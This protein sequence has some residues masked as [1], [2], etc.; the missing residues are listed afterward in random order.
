MAAAYFVAG[1]YYGLSY[2]QRKDYIVGC[3]KPSAALTTALY[4]AMESYMEGDDKA[5]EARGEADTQALYSIALE[6]CD[7]VTPYLDEYAA[8]FDALREREDWDAI[9]KQI[10]EDHQRASRSKHTIVDK[11]PNLEERTR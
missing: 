11:L 3:F 1:W 8:E 9:S 2:M 7:E 6:D 10:F 5:E 4:D